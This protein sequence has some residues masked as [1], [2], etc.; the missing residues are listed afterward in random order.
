MF[1]QNP[2]LIK[3][4]SGRTS[5]YNHSFDRSIRQVFCY[6]CLGYI[7]TQVKYDLQD[8]YVF[9][10]ANV[11]NYIYCPYCAHKFNKERVISNV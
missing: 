4:H 9:E 10:D 11:N 7:G 6:E 2:T 3:A 8:E 1:A 5:Y